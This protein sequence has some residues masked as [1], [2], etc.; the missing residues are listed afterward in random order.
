MRTNRPPAL[1]CWKE[2]AQYL[3][4]G[5]RT[6]QRWEREL[7]LPI[8]RP[9]NRSSGIVRAEPSELDAWMKVQQV[10]DG[11]NREPAWLLARV[12]QLQVENEIL[13]RAVCS[14]LARQPLELKWHSEEIPIESLWEQSA[15][16]LIANVSARHRQ[17]ELL[18]RSRQ[19][20][21]RIPQEIPTEAPLPSRNKVQ[22][23]I[24]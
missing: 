9:P 16:L 1:T 14:L 15:Q 17:Y 2:I 23:Q 21:S 7:G 3:H 5:V 22:P 11:D 18:E 20:R 13:R 10:A 6:V 12:E 24:N 19:I 4:K 8:H